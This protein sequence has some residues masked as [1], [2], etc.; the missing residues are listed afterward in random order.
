MV[1][2]AHDLAA[3]VRDGRSLVL[4][5]QGHDIDPDVV[6]PVVTDFMDLRVSHRG[7]SG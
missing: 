3:A 5:G 2:T 4:A 1:E 7:T 6:G